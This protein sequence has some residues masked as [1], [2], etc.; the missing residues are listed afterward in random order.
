[1]N[2]SSNL[3]NIPEVIKSVPSPEPSR[4][5]NDGD[6]IS[7]ICFITWP[8]DGG[9]FGDRNIDVVARRGLIHPLREVIGAAWYH[10]GFKPFQFGFEVLQNHG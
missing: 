6:S 4:H 9:F 1:M 8:T 3:N 2:V 10:R 5:A 7:I